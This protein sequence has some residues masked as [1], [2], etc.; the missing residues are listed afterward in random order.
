VSDETTN[1]TTLALR[2]AERRRTWI[3]IAIAS[4]ALVFAVWWAATNP[5]EPGP[6]LAP[7]TTPSPL[8]TMAPLPQGEVTAAA[9]LPDALPLTDEVLAQVESLW[10]LVTFRGDVVNDQGGVLLAGPTILYLVSPAA[11]VF[12]VANMDALGADALVAWDSTRG[13]ALLAFDD[14]EEVRTYDMASGT[15]GPAIDP[16]DGG[17]PLSLTVGTAGGTNWRLYTSC[18]DKDSD[19]TFINATS[20]GDRGELI[21]DDNL[22]HVAQKDSLKVS[23]DIHLLSRIDSL[24]AP[25]GDAASTTQWLEIDGVERPAPSPEFMPIC[26]VIG[27]GRQGA[28]AARCANARG[29]LIWELPTDG[30]DPLRVI[31]ADQFP[32]DSRGEELVRAASCAAGGALAVQWTNEAATEGILTLTQDREFTTVMIDQHPAS[33]CFGTSGTHMLIGGPE[34]LSLLD[35]ATGTVQPLIVSPTPA[36]LGLDPDQWVRGAVATYPDPL[37]GAEH[38]GVILSP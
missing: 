16:C 13:V 1:L 27:P 6:G 21:W 36:Q 38:Q 11:E 20:V 2:D 25:A 14:G 7:T 31:R 17:T 19:S 23:R 22:V 26:E 3:A 29:A 10:S 30:A 8:A 33:H 34:G 35:T 4:V 12:Q 32:V 37:A 28:I 9:G 5:F 15:L 18:R 24:E